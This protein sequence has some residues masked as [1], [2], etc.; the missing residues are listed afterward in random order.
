VSGPPLLIYATGKGINVELRV[1]ASSFWASQD[2]MAVMFGIK[3][4]TVSEHIARMP[5]P[6]A[7]AGAAR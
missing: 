1:E 4:N 6:L 5:I 2:Q 3:Q 7:Q